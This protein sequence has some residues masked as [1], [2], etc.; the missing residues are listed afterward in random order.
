M[1]V[2]GKPFTP[3]EEFECGSFIKLNYQDSEDYFKESLFPW[4]EECIER[5]KLTPALPTVMV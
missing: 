3:K 4:L 1:P 5:G 2:G